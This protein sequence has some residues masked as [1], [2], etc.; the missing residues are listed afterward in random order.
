MNTASEHYAGHLGPVYSWMVGDLDAASARATSELDALGL[1]R[2]ARGVAVDLGAGFGLHA[3][4][5]ARRGYSVIAIDSCQ[6][7][8]GELQRRAA[9]MPIRAV[10][11]D[12]LDFPKYVSKPVEVILCMGD[13]L[14]HLPERAS[15][16][17]LFADVAALL[18]VTGQFV[19]TFRDYVATPLEG[20]RRFIPVRSDE[21]R[22]LTCFLEY[23]EDTVT[24]HDLLHERVNGQSPLGT[25][26]LPRLQWQQRVSSYRK[27]RLHPEWVAA[28]LGERGLKVRTGAGPAGMTM[29]VATKG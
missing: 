16:E 10:V 9:G 29:V 11:G 28:K 18:T 2:D 20:D 17:H 26:P 23:G 12:I 1:P 14:T 24:V 13:T 27:L 25:S 7:L 8:V 5:L 4:P 6:T 15:V 3:L 19:A 22:I 21:N